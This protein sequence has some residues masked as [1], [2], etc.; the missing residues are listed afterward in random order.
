VY[1]GASW[2]CIVELSRKSVA[3][4]GAPVEFPDFTKGK[5]KTT[6]PLGIV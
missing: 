3:K 5:W 2:S 4:G 1:D 6:E